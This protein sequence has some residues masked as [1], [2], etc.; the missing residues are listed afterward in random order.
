M[1][2][3]E[4]EGS[5]RLTQATEELRHDLECKHMRKI[6][7]QLELIGMLK[8]QVHGVVHG[9]PDRSVGQINNDP[10]PSSNSNRRGLNMGTAHHK[11]ESHDIALPS[12][13]NAQPC[14][15]SQCSVVR[16]K[17][18]VTSLISVVANWTVTWSCWNDRDMLLQ[19]EFH[20][21]G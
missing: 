19:F 11:Q 10:P 12:T 16:D 6:E 14:N 4:Y 21:T 17:K 1:V 7:A 9:E 13:Q 15:H 18:M 20:L 5:C 2:D 8:L 3:M